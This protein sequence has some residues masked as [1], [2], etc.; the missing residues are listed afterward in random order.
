[1]LPFLYPNRTTP[2]CNKIL[3]VKRRWKS[4]MV[5]IPKICRECGSELEELKLVERKGNY[6]VFKTQCRGCG[7]EAKI[8]ARVRAT[9]VV[10]LDDEE[11]I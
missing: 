4:T 2:A 1:M 9:K 11:E 6:Y 7:R 8:L 10:W 5:S 3:S